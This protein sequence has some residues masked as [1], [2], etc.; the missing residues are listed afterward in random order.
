MGRALRTFRVDSQFLTKKKI[1]YRPRFWENPHAYLYCWVLQ[2]Q[3]GHSSTS[4]IHMHKYI[5]YQL[6]SPTLQV[7]QATHIHSVIYIKFVLQCS[8]RSLKA[9]RM[10]MRTYYV[11]QYLEIDGH[12]CVYIGLLTYIIIKP[13]LIFRLGPGIGSY[14]A[15]DLDHDELEV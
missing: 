2:V 11:Y 6:Y 13:L 8:S 10:H 12:S 14:L 3:V 4:T 15:I 9:W 1:W 7:G 5:Y